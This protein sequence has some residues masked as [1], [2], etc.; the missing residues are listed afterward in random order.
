MKYT[1]PVRRTKFAAAAVILFVVLVYLNNTSLLTGPLSDRPFLIA[2]R[3]LGQEFDREGLTGKSCTASRML[4]SEHEHLENTIPAMHVAFA[5]GAD[6]IG[7]LITRAG[8][9]PTASISS[10]PPFDAP[11]TNFAALMP[12]REFGPI[13]A[14]GV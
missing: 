7:P 4:P 14:I 6:Y 12:L 3:S 13:P 2:H 1:R 8:S 11:S 5:Y 9:G 10:V